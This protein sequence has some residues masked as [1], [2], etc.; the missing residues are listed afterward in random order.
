MRTTTAASVP[1]IVALALALG[2][3]GPTPAPVETTP[4]APAS[5]E[6][7][8]EPS[9]EPPADPL[10]AA[11]R[12]MIQSEI[13]YFG[14]EVAWALDGFMY[15]DDADAVRAKLTTAFDAEP[16]VSEE[17][18]SLETLPAT[19]YD[20]GG[21]V[22]GVPQTTRPRGHYDS[23]FVR[24]TAATVHG[25]TI[26]TVEGITIGSAAADAAVHAV[27][28][29]DWSGMIEAQLDPTPVTAEEIGEDPSW[30]GDLHTHVSVLSPSS[31]GPV[32]MLVAPARNFGN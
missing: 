31:G 7:S 26:E 8:T 15:T 11:T 2:G 24:A 10:A 22:L 30:G 17:P 13:V 9:E 16:T 3:C 28:V 5:A 1:L 20:W 18:G 25:I 14:D 12:I 19:L 21:F 4:S 32:T 6:P 29:I 23:L 27:D